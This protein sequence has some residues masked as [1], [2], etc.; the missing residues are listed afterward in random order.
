MFCFVFF[1]RDSTGL[2]RALSSLLPPSRFL[3]GV[4]GGLNTSRLLSNS[5]RHLLRAFRF[6]FRSAQSH[7]CSHGSSV[8]AGGRSRC[9]TRCLLRASA[10]GGGQ[11]SDRSGVAGYIS[12]DWAANY[13]REHRLTSKTYNLFSRTSPASLRHSRARGA[14]DL[15]DLVSCA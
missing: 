12:G 2:P 14:V 10:R 4:T 9:C 7:T 6:T 5:R 15:L 1:C 3:I 8:F 11:V 13:S